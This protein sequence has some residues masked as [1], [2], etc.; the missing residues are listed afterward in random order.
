MF[1]HSGG[2][3]VDWKMNLL[4]KKLMNFG[5]FKFWV[6]LEVGLLRFRNAHR[7][8]SFLRVALPQANP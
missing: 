8:D 7:H 2:N 6:T 4:M 3:S 5:I 1:K